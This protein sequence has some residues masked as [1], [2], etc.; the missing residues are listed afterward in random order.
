MYIVDGRPFI[1][2]YFA[3]R[4]RWDFSETSDGSEWTSISFLYLAF[5]GCQCE[6]LSTDQIFVD[7][8][9]SLSKIEM[10]NENLEGVSCSYLLHT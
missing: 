1:P 3:I 5:Q 4:L 7:K 10:P 9:H 6:R 2:S 8:F